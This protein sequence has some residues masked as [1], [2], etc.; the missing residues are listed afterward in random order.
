[1]NDLNWIVYETGTGIKS[2][3]FALTFDRG[4]ANG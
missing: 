1:M 2:E 4:G 3:A